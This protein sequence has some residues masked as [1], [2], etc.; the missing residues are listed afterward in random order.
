MIFSR[1]LT[2]ASLELNGGGA[3]ICDGTECEFE[4]MGVCGSMYRWR[5]RYRY[6]GGRVCA[7]G[8]GDQCIPA[9]GVPRSKVFVRETRCY[10]I[11]ILPRRQPNL[12]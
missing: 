9:Y 12:S 7:C 10:F 1:L 8:S 5:E 4:E 2:S 6:D 11:E 3:N